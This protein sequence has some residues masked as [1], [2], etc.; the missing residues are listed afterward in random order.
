LKENPCV[1]NESGLEFQVVFATDQGGGMVLRIP[2]GR[3]EVFIRTKVEK[4]TLDL[5]RRYANFEAPKWESYNEELIPLY[6]KN[7]QSN[8]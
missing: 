3:A 1:F 8:N 4:A 2:F 7:L 6:K 5:V